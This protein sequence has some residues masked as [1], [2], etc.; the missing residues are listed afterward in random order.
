MLA[1]MKTP[2]TQPLDIRGLSAAVVLGTLGALTIMIVPGFV[3]LIGAQS[4]LDDRRLGFV[5]SWDI[6]TTAAAIGLATFVIARVNWRHLASAGTALIVLGTLGTAMSHGYAPIVAAR[7]CTGLGEGLAIAVSLAALGSAANPDRAFCAYL[8]VGLTVSAGVLAL[9]PWLQASFGAAATFGGMAAVALASMI[10]LPWLPQRSPASALWW[11]ETPPV[12]KTLAVSGLVGVFLYFIAQGA[13]WSYFERIGRA[14]GVDPIIIGEAMGLSSFAG[15]GGALLAFA[16]VTRL[17]RV[18]P[19]IASGAVSI[20]SFWLLRG[21]VTATELVIAG[22]LFNFGWNLAQPLL[23]GVCAE[24]DAQGRV[25][26]AMGCIQT[27]GFGLGPA[28]AAVLL[29]GHDFSRAAWMSATVLIISLLIVLG[30][31]RMRRGGMLG[32]SA[33]RLG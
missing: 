14:S 25:V 15:M 6:N 4:G 20:L 24:A 7:V 19:L 26:V 30:G 8:I 11:D 31:L 29:R 16:L 9:L 1:S 32:I 2:S 23:S 21:Q 18:L 22:V 10:L 33:V 27:V 5:A 3:M 12:S 17:G 13:M 28:L